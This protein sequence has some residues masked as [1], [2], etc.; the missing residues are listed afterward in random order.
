MKKKL[1]NM[2]VTTFLAVLAIILITSSCGGSSNPSIQNETPT[3]G[4]TKIGIDES[5]S[6]L[7]DA[8]LFTFHNVYTNATITPIYKP[9]LAI[10]D[11]F[12]NDSVH[13]MI[14]TR[15]LT[16]SEEE[17]FSSKNIFPKTVTIAHDGLA[18]IV[19]KSN[20]DSL[21]RYNVIRDIFLG[22]IKSWNQISPTNGAGP[23]KVVFDNNKSSNVRFIREKFN[24]IDSFP[25]YCYAVD[26]NEEVVNYVEKHVNAIGIVGVNWISDKDDSITRGFLKRIRVVGITAEFDP[27]GPE[28]YKPYQAYIAD[29]SYPFIRD[30]Y[31]INRELYTGLGSGFLQYVASDPG[32]RIVLKMGMVPATMP[33]RL[34]KTRNNFE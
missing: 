3:R 26:R 4:K 20:R 16:K 1:N 29:K 21:I 24:I 23:L 10:L 22:K 28:Y 8:E 27:E 13:I 7:A 34:V 9:E 2:K 12:L 18:F 17:Y 32:Q 33:I 6:L 25:K 11:D 19:N 5:F 31:M 30:V 14:T 15:K